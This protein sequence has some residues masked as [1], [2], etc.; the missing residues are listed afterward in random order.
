MWLSTCSEL[1]LT[2]KHSTYTSK[3]NLNTTLRYTV[4]IAEVNEIRF[5][6]PI[7]HSRDP[8]PG[9]EGGHIFQ[10]LV[11]DPGWDQELLRVAGAEPAEDSDSLTGRENK[12]E[13]RRTNEL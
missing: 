13:R 10:L 11:R 6:R 8:L 4:H 12:R 9:A 7:N 1:S 2:Y 5:S 3:T